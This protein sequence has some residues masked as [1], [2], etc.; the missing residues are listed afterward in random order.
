[1]NLNKVSAR[2]E[3]KAAVIRAIT[4]CRE[5]GLALAGLPYTD[6]LAGPGGIH[7]QLLV[8]DAGFGREICEQAL[9]E[10][11]RERDV[12]SH[13]IK[14]CPT[15]WF[16]LASAQESTGHSNTRRYENFYTHCGMDWRTLLD[17]VDVDTC[18]ICGHDVAPFAHQSVDLDA[19]PSCDASKTAERL[20]AQLD[21]WATEFRTVEEVESEITLRFD[22]DT[23][24]TAVRQYGIGFRDIRH[25][26][27]SLLEHNE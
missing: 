23:R 4:W 3:E 9:R 8:P 11:Y 2:L 26:Y 14:V 7:L 18:P 12:V 17:M 21:D 13:S 6:E 10:G 27:Q 16:A 19:R 5:K 24:A 15:D 20:L 22:A 25:V 1:M